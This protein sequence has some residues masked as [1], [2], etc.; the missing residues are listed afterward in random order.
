MLLNEKTVPLRILVVI[1]MP[2][3]AKKAVNLFH[4]GNIT[5]QY[6]W[7]ASGTASSEMMD[8]LGLG[9]PEK[10]VLLTVLPKPFADRMGR[11]LKEAAVIGTKN[12]GIAFTLPMSGA[13]HLLLQM[14]EALQGEET[15]E[16]GK[17]GMEDMKY[18][19]IAAV[20]NQGYS[21]NVMEAARGAGA[22]GGT[23]IP[24][25]RTGSEEAIQFWGMSIQE[26]KEMILIITEQE[27]KLKIMQAIS[28]KCG[29]HS[30]ADGL[31]LSLP[32]DTVIGGNGG[33]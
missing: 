11:K 22:G 30:E 15:N 16:R 26:E 24:G 23:V 5:L 13:N 33:R 6:E 20:V 31:V 29:L 2:R 1:T 12:S 18:A 10:R 9:T 14:L 17:S 27:N 8:I 28:A 7:N 3:L 25:R 4:E 21:E 32:I 19:L